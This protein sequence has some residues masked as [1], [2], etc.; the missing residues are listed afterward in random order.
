[1]NSIEA[2]IQFER[3]LI[4]EEGEVTNPSTEEFLRDYLTEFHG[5]IERVHMVLPRNR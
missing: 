5:F 2:Y 3:G 4:P 1:M